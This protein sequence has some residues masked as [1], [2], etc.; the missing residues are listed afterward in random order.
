MGGLA[1]TMGNQTV[2]P[3]MKEKRIAQL[4]K[5]GEKWKAIM[6]ERVDM[7]TREKKAKEAVE[8]YMLSET[9]EE[10]RLDDDRVFT[11][12]EG[13]KHLVVVKS[14]RKKDAQDE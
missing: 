2:L 14:K 5:L 6:M 11:I 7:S 10:Y 12:E 13:E 4:Q 3:G 1:K 8:K 9:I